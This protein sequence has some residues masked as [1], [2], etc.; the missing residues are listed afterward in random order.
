[1]NLQIDAEKSGVCNVMVVV[2]MRSILNQNNGGA[3]D[4]LAELGAIRLGRSG[5]D[6]SGGV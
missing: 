6:P 4:T 3:C 5:S 2:L 1:M